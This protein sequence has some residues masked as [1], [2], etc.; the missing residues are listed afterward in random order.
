[1]ERPVSVAPKLNSSPATADKSARRVV[2]PVVSNH[3]RSRS[4]VYWRVSSKHPWW[5]ESSGRP[6]DVRILIASFLS[7]SDL[8]SLSAV[9]KESL[10]F[11]RLDEIWGP[12]YRQR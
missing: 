11:V 12:L 3:G 5:L 7:E 2:S 8:A 9:N 10:D 4:W 1:M 6:T